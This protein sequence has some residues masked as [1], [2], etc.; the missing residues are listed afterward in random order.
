LPRVG[1]DSLIFRQIARVKMMRKAE[2]VV[3]LTWD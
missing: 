2:E 3:V 1:F